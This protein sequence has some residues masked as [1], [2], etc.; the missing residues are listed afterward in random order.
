MILLAEKS[1]QSNHLALQSLLLPLRLISKKMVDKLKPLF[2]RDSFQKRGVN[3]A[4]FLYTLRCF[5][6]F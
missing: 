1:V 5:T 6:P 3:F 4:K 2:L